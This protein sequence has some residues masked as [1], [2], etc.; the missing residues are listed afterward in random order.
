MLVHRSSADSL[1]LRRI[2]SLMVNVEELFVI[3][4]SMVIWLPY[5]VGEKASCPVFHRVTAAIA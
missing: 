1:T 2:A 5:M 4:R 3:L